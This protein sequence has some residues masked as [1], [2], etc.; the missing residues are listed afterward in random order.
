MTPMPSGTLSS[1]SLKYINFRISLQLS[2]INVLRCFYQLDRPVWIVLRRQRLGVV[3][4][5]NLFLQDINIKHKNNDY[6]EIWLI[7]IDLCLECLEVFS[8]KCDKRACLTKSRWF[9]LLHLNS[10]NL[11]LDLDVD[12]AGNL[13]TQGFKCF[14]NFFS[15]FLYLRNP[16]IGNLSDEFN[17][18]FNL[19][20]QHFAGLQLLGPFGPHHKLIYLILLLPDV[21]QFLNCSF[22]ELSESLHST[23]F[24]LRLMHLMLYLWD[25]SFYLLIGLGFDLKPDIL[26]LLHCWRGISG[27]GAISRLVMV[28]NMQFREMRGT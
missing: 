22:P 21:F 18:L 26:D 14:L 11:H 19:F 13:G 12:V 16:S 1:G 10:F 6:S 3:K 2:Q 25:I 15:P 8:F 28:G 27:R 5:L 23:Q 20:L 7:F 17:L 4:G 24:L 9:I